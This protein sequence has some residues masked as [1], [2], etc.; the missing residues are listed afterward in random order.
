M[1]KMIVFVG[2]VAFFSSA[3]S[4]TALISPFSTKLPIRADEVYL[5]VG[6]TGRLIS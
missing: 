2:L 5:P 4:T 3:Y 1:K 6:A